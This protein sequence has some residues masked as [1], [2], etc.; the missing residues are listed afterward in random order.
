MTYLAVRQSKELE[1]VAS[2]LKVESQ[3]PEGGK[4]WQ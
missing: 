2:Q 4:E 1:K 3:L